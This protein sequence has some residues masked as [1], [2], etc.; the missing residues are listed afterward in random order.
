MEPQM[1]L[2]GGNAL[3][4][5]YGR[6]PYNTRLMKCMLYDNFPDLQAVLIFEGTVFPYLEPEVRAGECPYFLETS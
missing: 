3:L 5:S 2:I 1:L 4:L 6:Q